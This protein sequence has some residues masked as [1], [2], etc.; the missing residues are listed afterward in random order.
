[1]SNS[2]NISSLSKKSNLSGQINQNFIPSIPINVN[3]NFQYQSNYNTNTSHTNLNN[4]VGNIGNIS[5]SNLGSIGSIGNVGN[6]GSFNNSQ[7]N[8]GN[9]NQQYFSLIQKLH[10]QQQLNSNQS[11]I[12]EIE[13][14]VLFQNETDSVRDIVLMYKTKQC[15]TNCSLDEAECFFW[16]SKKYKRRKPFNKDKI[17]Y[18]PEMCYFAE[19][20]KNDNC[21]KAHN[22]NEI[23]FHP[24]RYKTLLCEQFYNENQDNLIS[25]KSNFTFNSF[26]S[27]T[28]NMNSEIVIRE[29]QQ[30]NQKLCPFYH[31]IEEKRENIENIKKR[32]SEIYSE[33]SFFSK[34]FN[35]NTY[36]TIKCNIFSKHPEK[37]CIFYHSHSDRRRPQSSFFYLPEECF[38]S[39]SEKISSKNSGCPKG[40]QC[41]KC[42]NKVELFYHKDKFKTK[43]CTYYS[44]EKEIIEVNLDCEYGNFC[45]FAHSE[46]EIRIELIHK[47]NM[48]IN[49]FFYYF[50]TVQCPFEKEHEKKDCVY[51]HNYQDFRRNPKKFIYDKKNCKKWDIKKT[52]LTYKDGCPEG[53]NCIYCHGW[54]EL[55]YHPLNYKTNLCK[56]CTGKE[57]NG[58]IKGNLCPCYHRYENKR[59]VDEELKR[60]YDMKIKQKQSQGFKFTYSNNNSN[61]QTTNQLSQNNS[62]LQAIH[63]TYKSFMN[64]SINSNMNNSNNNSVLSTSQ[65]ITNENKSIKSLKIGIEQ[66]YLFNTKFSSN[67]S[68]NVFTTNTSGITN[69]S[70]GGSDIENN[71]SKGPDPYS[72]GLETS[73]QL[74]KPGM[75]NINSSFDLMK[76]EDKIK[77]N[78]KLNEIKGQNEKIKKLLEDDKSDEEYDFDEGLMKYLDENGFNRLLQMVEK[79]ELE[80]KDFNDEDK[81]YQYVEEDKKSYFEDLISFVRKMKSDDKEA[82]DLLN[83]IVD[84]VI[85]DENYD[86]G[87]YDD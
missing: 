83:S 66:N 33:Q 31:N 27:N 37:Q 26:N 14:W 47:M 76:G 36:K 78:M 21:G 55:D 24:W 18:K 86:E 10:Y 77:T 62:M 16:H 75:L 74:E 34:N 64:T 58:C 69:K 70:Y 17:L 44:S 48:D 6:L 5:L 11:Q 85:G 35:L 73:F 80:L 56:H 72:S 59:I 29:N 52:I 22:F 30:H 49:F 1:M 43:F 61:F 67:I 45:C 53:Y 3:M 23:N 8:Q 20:C 19:D 41:G 39:Y 82:T 38:F 51:Y 60:Q 15:A 42:H 50:K 25:P 2:C 46:S 9:Q 84:K 7:M 79:G 81:I 65:H 28:L 40:D 68:G 63:P 87:L 71:I 13:D 4:N 32:S 54:K 12:L 57:K